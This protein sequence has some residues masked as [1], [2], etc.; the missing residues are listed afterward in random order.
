MA[1]LFSNDYTILYNPR[2]I[3]IKKIRKHF[4]GLILIL[5]KKLFFLLY[6]KKKRNR[7]DG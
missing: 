6:N 4:K 5:I 3:R 2:S 7:I 1:N